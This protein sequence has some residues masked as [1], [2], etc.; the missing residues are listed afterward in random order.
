MKRKLFRKPNITRHTSQVNLKDVLSGNI[1]TKDFFLR[2]L[3]L[4]LLIVF[5]TFVY[6]NNGFRAQNQQRTINTLQRAIKE[7]RYE[8]LDLSSE[9]TDMTKRSTISE[10]LR[11]NNSKV[12]E[13]LYPAILIK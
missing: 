3:P 9:Y 4:I 11:Q 13:S 7:A 5:F 10:Q 6:I 2:Q 12:H 8:M 1:L